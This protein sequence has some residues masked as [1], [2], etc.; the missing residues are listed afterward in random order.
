ML[1]RPE[2]LDPIDIGGPVDICRI[3]RTGD[4]ETALRHHPSSID[5]Q[6]LQ[7]WLPVRAVR[8]KIS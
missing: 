3:L 8:A 1:R 2:V 6:P 4:Y 7:R 5:Q